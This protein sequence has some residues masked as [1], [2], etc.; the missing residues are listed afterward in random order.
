M[1]EA[2]GQS[3]ES[4]WEKELRVLLQLIETHPSADMS[5]ERERIV[6][7]KNLMATHQKSGNQPHPIS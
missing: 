5:K 7:L 3:L 4:E 6:V 2:M 1:E